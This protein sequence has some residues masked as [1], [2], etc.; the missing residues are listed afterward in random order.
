MEQPIIL[1]VRMYQASGDARSA[2]SSRE[3]FAPF[4]PETTARVVL[5]RIRKLLDAY[6][7]A[8]TL[9][10]ARALELLTAPFSDA[11]LERER[12]FAVG[13]LHW[14]SDAPDG[15]VVPWSEVVRCAREQNATESLA[16]AAYWLAR[17][18]L[19]GGYGE[20][21]GEFEN[22]LRTLGGLPRAAAWF[23]DLL[24]RAGRVDRA[25]QVWKSVRGNRRVAGCA[26]GTLL[27]A[28]MLLKRDEWTQAERLLGEWTPTTAVA[29]VERM[30]LLAWIAA[31][32]NR[33]DKARA[34]LNQAQAGLYPQTALQDWS[35]RIERRLGGRSCDDGKVSPTLR[36]FIRGQQL[37]RDGRIEQAI[38]AYRVAETNPSIQPFARYALVCLGREDGAEL[39]SQQP[40]LFLAVR[41]RARLTIERFRR[42]EASPAE[43][44]DAL[45][46]AESQGYQEA[47]S[48]HFQSLALFLQ[49]RGVDIETV[50]KWSAKSCADR[51]GSNA[52][53]AAVEWAINHFTDIENRDLFLEWSQRSDLTEELRSLVERQRLRLEPD[54]LLQAIRSESGHP[55]ARLW[56][57]ARRLDPKAADAETWCDE[58]R[59][60][61]SLPH[62]RGMAQALLLQKAFESGD[63]RTVAELLEETDAW[64]GLATP[65][66]FVLR[67]LDSICASGPPG[68]QRVLA[69]WLGLWEPSSLGQEAAFLLS[70]AGLTPLR[71][72]E[73]EPPP[74]V[75]AVP[76]FLHRAARALGR[77][78][79]REAFAFVRRALARDP[80]LDGTPNGQTVR[81][82][83]P[84]LQRLARA[85]TL[86]GTSQ[87]PGALVDVVV[88]LEDRPDGA[89]VLEALD[90]GDSMAALAR[91]ETMSERDDLSPRL[92][93]HLALLM[94]RTALER[95]ESDEIEYAESAW[96]RS[97]HCWLRFVADSPEARRVLVESLL[98]RHRRR[99]NDLLTR[100]RVDEARR[101][102]NMVRE[103]PALVG[104]ID[105]A[106]R[107]ELTEC[108]E[109]FREE[110]A[111]EYLLTT[112]EAMRFGAI[113]EGWRADYEK[114][115][116]HLRRLLSLDRDHP[117][118]LA[119]LVEICNDWFL[120][121]YHQNDVGALR[122]QLE[123]FTPFAL[124]LARRIDERP[125]ELTARAALSDFWKFRG[126][127]AEDPAR[128]IA[129][130]REA[131][132]WNPANHNVRDLL[133]ETTTEE[134]ET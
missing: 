77:E 105:D 84:H 5:S 72:D 37:R 26:E 13:W 14:L 92:A 59:P 131:L 79:A 15:A 69:R 52:F 114:G 90:S 73:A 97:W 60:L 2:E 86:A 129:L 80:A 116:T 93:H 45:R 118:L 126:F 57:A 19:A 130:Y 123:R 98:R 120:D 127:V 34:W 71:G 70:H 42:R 96:R 29:W 82:A 30:L 87:P 115:L 41:C 48:K 108:V 47:A 94:Q 103:L 78:D 54:A 112:R 100:S 91:L 68:W 44:L 95:E 63:D 28:R 111:T 31:H 21:L 55:A 128:K 56:R 109:R 134:S 64:R 46:L 83:L 20:A 11:N 18:R 58:V 75:A 40:G 3:T 61:L 27:E 133:G 88:A 49:A 33:A 22:V 36:V 107:G 106:L 43:L 74:G 104:R 67:A 38:A 6:T 53:R 1:E 65:P 4:S 121:L 62:W 8:M 35:A 124:Q 110:L 17:V 76:W 132:R 12:L 117:R 122:S 10:C 39:L 66:P 51:E 23:V 99:I 7:P 125:G 101:Y 16:E 25:E 32:Q 102:A 9:E 85:Q 50:R 89:D 113:P 119:A 81:D 24:A